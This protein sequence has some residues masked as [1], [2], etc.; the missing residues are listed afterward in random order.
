MGSTSFLPSATLHE[1]H[2]L[3]P[4]Q[5]LPCPAV[6]ARVKKSRKRAEALRLEGRVGVGPRRARRK[7]AVCATLVATTKI[8]VTT[9]KR[10]RQLINTH[11]LLGQ[12][13]GYC[14]DDTQATTN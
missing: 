12:P 4:T 3:V 9:F 5:Q 10:L 6:R 13:G 8:L 14:D 1:P 2:H 11:A 7:D